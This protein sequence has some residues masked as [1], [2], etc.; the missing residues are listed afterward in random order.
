MLDRDEIL[1]VGSWHLIKDVDVDYLKRV[2]SAGH[3]LTLYKISD[4]DAVV[5]KAGVHWSGTSTTDYDYSKVSMGLN[6]RWL[7]FIPPMPYGMVP[8]TSYKYKENLKKSD[9]KYVVSDLHHGF[10]DGKKYLQKNLVKLCLLQLFVVLRNFQCLSV[11]H[12]GACLR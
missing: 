7:N 12:L 3:N 11:V 10:V 4:D 2:N 1:S 9:Y 5:G 6:Y 8:I